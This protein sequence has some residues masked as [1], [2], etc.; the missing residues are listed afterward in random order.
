MH[1]YFFS[2]HMLGISWRTT[3]CP[4]FKDICIQWLWFRPIPL[5][6]SPCFSFLVILFLFI[7]DIFIEFRILSLLTYPLGIFA[8]ESFAM[9]SMKAPPSTISVHSPMYDLPKRIQTPA[10]NLPCPLYTQNTIHLPR[11]ISPPHF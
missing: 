3:Y 2:C 9:I 4:N 10:S 1:R 7:L 6:A 8:R 11:T 5:S